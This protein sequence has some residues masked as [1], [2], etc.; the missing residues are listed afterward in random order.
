MNGAILHQPLRRRQPS[1]IINDAGAKLTKMKIAPIFHTL[2]FSPRASIIFRF[3]MLR[4]RRGRLSLTAAVSI[5]HL[6][7]FQSEII[8]KITARLREISQR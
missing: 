3:A 1:G 4:D 7:S 5:H 8:V 6:E 2:R